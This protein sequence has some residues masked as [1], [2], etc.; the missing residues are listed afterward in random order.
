MKFTTTFSFAL[1]IG[2]TLGDPR[3]SPRTG[4]YLNFKTADLIALRDVYAAK[5]PSDKFRLNSG[6]LASNFRDSLGTA[7][8]TVSNKE[9]LLH[10]DTHVIKKDLGYTLSEMHKHCCEGSEECQGGVVDVL[11]DN[12]RWAQLEL[13]GAFKQPKIS[14]SK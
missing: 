4:T 7:Y 6:A 12:G 13:R 2:T 5:D 10:R 8:I 1:A 9:W 11:G 14:E 3:C